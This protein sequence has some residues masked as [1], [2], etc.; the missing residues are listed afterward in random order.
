[1]AQKFWSFTDFFAGKMITEFVCAQFVISA[2][3]NV[4]VM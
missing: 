2:V 3:G 4:S 1:M